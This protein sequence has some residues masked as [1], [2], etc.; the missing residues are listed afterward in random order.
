M[1]RTCVA[2][3]CVAVM[4]VG[5]Q[6]GEFVEFQTDTQSFLYVSA[7]MLA[8]GA[9]VVAGAELKIERHGKAVRF[10]ARHDGA[11]SASNWY[12]QT[13]AMPFVAYGTHDGKFREV[14]NRV[15]I[16]LKDPAKL[17]AI[18]ARF[19]A[20]RAKH[21]DGLG[22]ALLWFDNQ[23]NPLEVAN[24]LIAHPD[25]LRVEPQFKRPRHFPL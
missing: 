10:V 15:R 9:K 5:A 14:A 17:K 24:R 20:V 6:T 25:V 13:K 11:E 18:A 19:N 3:I 2:V 1:L 21:Y 16:E 4:S 23:R 22:F 12:S 8:D 7:D